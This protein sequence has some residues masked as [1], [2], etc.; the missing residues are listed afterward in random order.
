M[1]RRERAASLRCRRQQFVCKQ[2]GGET[3]FARLAE[4]SV[5]RITS[6]IIARDAAVSDRRT[7][8]VR[9]K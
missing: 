4:L 3:I 5:Q 6:R 8:A 1:A 9:F 2:V 7:H